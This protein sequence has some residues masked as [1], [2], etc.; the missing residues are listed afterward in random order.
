MHAEHF[1]FCGNELKYLKEVLDTGFI[2]GTTGNMN[3]RLE[4]AFAAKFGAQY[5]I[6][7][8]S[9]TSGLHAALAACGVG[10]GDEVILPAVTV[11]MCGLAVMQLGAKPVF[12]DVGV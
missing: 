8:N 3:K 10:P 11:V 9:A 4:E 5:A 6:T 1:R 12:A 2:S 7:V